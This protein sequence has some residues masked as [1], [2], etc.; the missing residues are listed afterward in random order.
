MKFKGYAPEMKKAT[1]I[2]YHNNIVVVN[3][4]MQPMVD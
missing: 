1:N 2:T 3:K 4:T